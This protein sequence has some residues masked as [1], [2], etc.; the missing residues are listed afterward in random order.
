[1]R[2]SYEKI[3]CGEIDSLQGCSQVAVF[4]SAFVLPQFRHKGI[5]KEAHAQRLKLA[6]ESC[7]NYAICTVAETNEY[8][9]K[10][11]EQF[12]WKKLDM[13]LSSKTQHKVLIYGKDME[14]AND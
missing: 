3:A 14:L 11:L 6:K 1:M 4:H 10:I 2:T 8:Q 12:G 13:F 5:A 9:I 7:Y